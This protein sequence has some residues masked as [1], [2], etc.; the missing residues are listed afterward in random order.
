M[1]RRI[2]HLVDGDDRED[3][4][5]DGAGALL[6][7]AARSPMGTLP[8][9]MMPPPPPA[10]LLTASIDDFTLHA[11]TASLPTTAMASSA[12]AAMALAH[13]SRT[14]ACA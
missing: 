9:T 7:D 1:V 5:D 6:A 2:H 14:S 13:R 12:S 3:R 11:D 8:F 10:K 4:D